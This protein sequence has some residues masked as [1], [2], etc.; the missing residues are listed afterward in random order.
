MAVPS[1][2]GLRPGKLD[3]GVFR[4]EVASKVTEKPVPFFTSVEL[5]KLD[6]AC[7]GST[8]A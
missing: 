7:R 2:R 5:S 6:K 4:A 3:V 8:F 1:R